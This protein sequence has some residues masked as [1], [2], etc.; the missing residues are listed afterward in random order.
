MSEAARAAAK[1]WADV[2]RN[3]GVPDNGDKPEAGGLTAML[4]VLSQQPRA[5][6][7]KYEAF[8]VALEARIAG[9]LEACGSCWLGVDYHPDALL[10]GAANDVG[11]RAGMGDWPWKTSMDVKPDRVRVA[12]G[13]QAEFK[14]I[15][16]AESA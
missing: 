12:K 6:P 11:I 2:L 13:Y 16:P 10:Q 4:A 8:Q 14:T 3:P 7:A 15:Y 1:W 5:E 9:S